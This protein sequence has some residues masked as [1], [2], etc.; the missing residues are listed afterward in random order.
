M[1]GHSPSSVADAVKRIVRGVPGSRSAKVIAA[2]ARTPPTWLGETIASAR[3]VVSRNTANRALFIFDDLPAALAPSCLTPSRTESDVTLCA[4]RPSRSEPNERAVGRFEYGS[5]INLPR[6]SSS[7]DAAVWVS[8]EVESEIARFVLR[9]I[10]RALKP[11]GEL[12]FA[13]VGKSTSLDLRHSLAAARI[14]FDEDE[15]P[16]APVYSFSLRKNGGQQAGGLPPRVRGP[17]T[18]QAR[19]HGSPS[20]ICAHRAEER[21]GK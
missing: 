7:I 4:D 13:A 17:E 1:S 19:S 20:Y 15:M 16:L 21:R 10:F 2:E 3:A 5:L 11:G 14:G 6:P 9:E 8:C 18:T 12:V